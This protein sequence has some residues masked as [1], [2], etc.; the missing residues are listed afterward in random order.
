MEDEQFQK[1]VLRELHRIANA[2]N[3]GM[4]VLAVLA[5]REGQAG[6]PSVAEWQNVRDLFRSAEPQMGLEAQPGQR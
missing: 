3:A 1:E 4:A 6:E 2:V 5:L